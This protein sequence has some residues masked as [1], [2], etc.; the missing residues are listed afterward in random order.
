MDA[1]LCV[2]VH[3]YVPHTIQLCVFLDTITIYKII[4][5]V[6]RFSDTCKYF[7]Y[8]LEILH[9]FISDVL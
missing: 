6:H 7:F 9:K 8:Y 1:W 3:L 2:Y 5:F 4:Y